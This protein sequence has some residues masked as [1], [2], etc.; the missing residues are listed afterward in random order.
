MKSLVGEVSSGGVEP[1][2]GIEQVAKAIVQM[3]KVTQSTAAIASRMTP[4]GRRPIPEFV[5]DFQE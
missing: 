5:I 1:S 4:A 3:G 2:R